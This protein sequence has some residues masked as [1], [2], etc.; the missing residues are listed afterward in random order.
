MDDKQNSQAIFN[1][2]GNFKNH[3]KDQKP[4]FSLKRKPILLL[5]YL[6]NKLESWKYAFL[7]ISQ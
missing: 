4:H 2:Y 1:Y 6:K 7:L 3:I 5:L